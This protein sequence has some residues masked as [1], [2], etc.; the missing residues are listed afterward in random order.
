MYLNVNNMSLGGVNWCL[1]LL[2]A[3]VLLAP[4]AGAQELP[5]FVDAVDV[6]VVNI[7]VVVTDSKDRPVTGLSRDDFEL[8]VDGKP[9][10]LSNFFAVTE[11]RPVMIAG[12][13]LNAPEA[14]TTL[15]ES[16]Q[17]NM[18]VLVD[19]S[20]LHGTERREALAALR[21]FLGQRAGA[22]QRI[23]L[24]RYSDSLEVHSE[25]TDD[26]A[27]VMAGIDK[28]ES[29][30]PGGVGR[31]AEWSRIVRTIEL[32]AYEA[33][34]QDMMLHEIRTYAKSLRHDCRQ[35]ISMLKSF[36]DR[37][38]GLK[39]RKAVVFVSDGMP[40]RPGE[41]LFELYNS[42]FGGNASAMLQA[43]QFSI[44]HD[45]DSLIDHANASRVTFYTMNSGGWSGNSLMTRAG[46]VTATSIISRDMAAMADINHT[47]T[48][49][50]MAEDTG[51][52]ALRRA[53]LEAFQHVADD[54]DAYYS[55]GFV[56]ADPGRVTTRKIKVNVRGKG[57]SLRYR[58]GFR[59]L[60]QEEQLQYEAMAD[61]LSGSEE[62]PLQISVEVGSNGRKQGRAFVVPMTVRVPT[63]GLAFIQD[64]DTFR[65]SL[66]IHVT[67]EDDRGTVDP[68]SATVP[69]SLPENVYT[70]GG[71][72]EIVYELEVKL[73]KGSTRISVAVSDELGGDRATTAAQVE[74]AKDGATAVRS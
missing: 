52:K 54:L 51:G 18:I 65:A 69:I 60:S 71:V 37:L 26:G 72:P 4:A 41:S 19:D 5:Y 44:K 11:G 6:H 2:P 35:K 25:L 20:S 67:G 64:G 45:I 3:I 31:F 12:S 40:M 43:G 15:P 73:R 29:S 46:A 50:G 36:I 39:G 32:G 59:A 9:V 61:L 49:S 1:L 56:P 17:L 16:Q 13:E 62:N 8:L 38:V 30:V 22:G 48:L 28:I 47:E 53:S 57:L 55:L 33:E 14:A 24:V 21:Q 34:H 23:M 66:V 74:V 10:E 27:K 68:F 7:E 70:S 63:D 42:H 58:R